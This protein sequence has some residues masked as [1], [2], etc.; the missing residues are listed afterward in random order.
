MAVQAILHR[1][2][3]VGHDGED[4]IGASGFRVLRQLDRMSRRIGSGSGDDRNSA[5]RDINR[6]ANENVMFCRPQRWRF[7]RCSADH[8]CGG[9]LA[10]LAFAEM[11]ECGDIDITIIIKGR[12]YGGRVA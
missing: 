2:V 10:D 12:R 11:F 1:L 4:G 7:A 3:V 8:K 9:T 5:A 6:N